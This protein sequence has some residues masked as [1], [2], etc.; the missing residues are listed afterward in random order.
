MGSP[1]QAELGRVTAWDN[2]KDFEDYEVFGESKLL[3]HPKNNTLEETVKKLALTL[4][5]I[6]LAAMA[7]APM[8][9]AQEPASPDEVQAKLQQMAT[10]LQLTPDQIAKI[11]PI[12]M[13]EAPKV[14]ALK[15]DTSMPQMQKMKQM[16]QLG[17]GVDAQLKPILT[18]EQ[19]QKFQAMRMKQRDEMM[20][21]A[22]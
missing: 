21:K 18:P 7:G 22:Q 13:A 2:I 11:K 4:F 14:Q 8:V 1:V 20:Q 9:S 15:A 6:L 5:A 3:Y 10:E 12:L 16:K 19:Y 17:D